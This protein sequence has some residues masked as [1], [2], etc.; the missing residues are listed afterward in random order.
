[1]IVV[2]PQTVPPELLDICLLFGVSLMGIY[3]RLSE[4]GQTRRL[5]DVLIERG[6]LSGN[7]T[8]GEKT[9]LL[10]RHLL[11]WCNVCTAWGVYS[12]IKDC[13]NEIKPP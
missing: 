10:G 5:R 9:N 8:D 13:G 2:N 12:A 7:L 11:N 4:S 1:M 3:D 6:I